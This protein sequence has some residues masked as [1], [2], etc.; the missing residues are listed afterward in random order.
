M[1]K[2]EKKR[3]REVAAVRVT[4]GRPDLLRLFAKLGF[5]SERFITALA[6]MGIEVRA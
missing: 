4:Y 2:Q 6:D 5:N 1:S 3:S